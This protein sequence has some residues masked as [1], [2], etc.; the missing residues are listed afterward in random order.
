MAAP[1]RIPPENRVNFRASAFDVGLCRVAA[2]DLSLIFMLKNLP[3]TVENV[4]LNAG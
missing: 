1:V 2:G 4:P 3:L